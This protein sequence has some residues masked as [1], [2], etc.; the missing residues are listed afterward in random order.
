MKKLYSI[1][2]LV[3]LALVPAYIVY[4]HKK[5]LMIK[6]LLQEYDMSDIVQILGYDPH[7]TAYQATDLAANDNACTI[8]VHGWGESQ[9]AISYLKANTILLPGTVI[10]FN[11]KDANPHPTKMPKLSQTNFCQTDDIASLIMTLKVL[12][13]CNVPVFHLFGLS[14]GAGTIVTTISRLASYQRFKLF[15]K[16]LHI[17]Q[18]QAT[19][20]LEKIK[21]GSIVLNC[22]LIDIN[23]SIKHKLAPYHAAWLSPVFSYGVLPLITNYS[24]MKDCPL[25]AAKRIKKL[26]I[27]TL[28]HF[29]KNDLIVGNNKEALFFAALHGTHS[30]LVLGNDC[31]G[32]MHCGETLA[33]ALHAFRKKYHGSYLPQDFLLEEGERLLSQSPIKS[34]DIQH[35]IDD[36]YQQNAYSFSPQKDVIWQHKFTQ[37]DTNKITSALGYDPCVRIYHG[38]TRVKG[39]GTTVYVHGYGDNYQFTVP[40]F[41]RNSYFL[42]GTVVSFHFQDVTDNAFK[43]K[44]G[45]SS[46]GQAADIATLSC[47]LKMLDDCHLDVIH[48]FGY[49]RGGATTINTLNRLCNYDYHTTFFERLGINK[50]QAQ[51]IVAKIQKGTITLNCPLVDS[52]SVARYW[53]GPL[54]KLMLNRIIPLLTEHRAYEDQA[55][56]GALAIQKMN[57]KILVHFQKHDTTLGNNVSTDATFYSNLKG[58]HTYLV[59]ADEGG[60]MHAG[61]T[62]NKITQ[63]FRK[64][65]NA[66]YYPFSSLVEEGESLLAQTP[67]DQTAIKNYVARMYT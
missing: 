8:Y 37:Y 15:F 30:Y 24:P 14:R 31:A 35:Y 40:Y 42:P 63:A 39:A 27:P 59:I 29:Q 11:F 3:L 16:K 38:D 41:Q 25:K 64:K 21:N 22:P 44:F 43:L 13:D 4:T 32:H 53:F 28:V 9:H 19:H 60:H 61:T 55:I 62:L 20:I 45:K 58:P 33:P 6:T 65:Y 46:V 57:F 67:Q 26:N 51:R 56:N 1:F 10:G 2:V 36:F 49:S 12:D 7:I 47:T 17:T 23:E 54:E 5:R 66:P 34:T 52:A 48:L 50:V 18:E